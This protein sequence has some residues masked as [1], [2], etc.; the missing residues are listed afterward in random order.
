MP[1]YNQPVWRQK[2]NNPTTRRVCPETGNL[3]WGNFEYLDSPIQQ[4]EDPKYNK[5]S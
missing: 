4:P 3:S 1:E 2:A 5:H